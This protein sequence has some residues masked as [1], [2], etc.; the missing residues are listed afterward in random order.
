M[1]T[2][3]TVEEVKQAVTSRIAAGLHPTGSR[4]PTVRYL[5]DELGANRNTVNKAYRQLCDTGVIELGP[6]QKSFVVSRA[7]QLTGFSS[8]FQQQAAAVVWQG[9]A[10]GIPRERMLNDLAAIVA[11]VYG[12]HRLRMKFIECNRY[13]SDELATNL[14]ELVG[15]PIEACVLDEALARPKR[16]AQSS[17]LIVTT[18]HHLAEVTHGFVSQDVKI[19]GV[20]TRPSHETLLGVA[21]M[22]SPRIGLVCTQANTARTLQHVINSYH[23]NH[24]VSV[25]LID[26][27]ASVRRVAQSCSQF[28]VTRNCVAPF[29]A[30]AHRQP[31][32]VVDFR[33]DEQS[34]SYLKQR[35][36]QTKLELHAYQTTNRST[37]G[38]KSHD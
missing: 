34:I 26:D 31:D 19:V 20:D 10:A 25:G 36:Q 4:L 9:M 38:P 2:R 29:T 30:I 28:A 15:E 23:P 8:Q 7:N 32:V 14:T 3:V 24:E 12:A 17:D 35:I 22:T 11:D 27:P 33:I 1:K 6:G 13:E 18:F 5:A 21:R 37:Y 16:F